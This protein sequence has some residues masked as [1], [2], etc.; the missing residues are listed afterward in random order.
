MERKN[1]WATDSLT[2]S[3]IKFL[4]LFIT[5]LSDTVSSFWRQKEM[6]TKIEHYIQSETRWKRKQ[7]QNKNSTSSD[8]SF[9]LSL[10]L[11]Y[12]LFSIYPPLGLVA[13]KTSYIKTYLLFR[14]PFPSCL[15]KQHP[16]WVSFSTSLNAI[17]K[18]FCTQV[19]QKR[20]TGMVNWV[21]SY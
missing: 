7:K 17:I 5:L 6:F 19:P 14:F 18:I 8:N 11:C 12:S 9:P 1:I 20:E 16:F 2:F 4:F 3:G 10:L 21:F 13:S 15:E